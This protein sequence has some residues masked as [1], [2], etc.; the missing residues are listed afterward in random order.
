M[1]QIYYY[2]APTTAP[3]TLRYYLLNIYTPSQHFMFLVVFDYY[4]NWT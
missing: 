2:T 4:H 1:G 3:T